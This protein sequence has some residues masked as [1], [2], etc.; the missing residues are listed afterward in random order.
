MA[1][2]ESMVDRMTNYFHRQI[3]LYEE[4]LAAYETLPAD[5]QAEDLDELSTRQ[6]GFSRRADQLEEELHLLTREWHETE[7]L[8][9]E[10]R[11]QVRGLAQTAQQLAQRLEVLSYEAADRAKSR[12][13]EVKEELDSLQRGY[14][15]L[16]RYRAGNGDSTS[17]YMDTKV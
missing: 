9:D 17:G 14:Q 3:A 1:R 6:A 16:D 12:L 10:Q 2:P 11:E 4:M 15:M 7:T 8:S 13:A 5:L